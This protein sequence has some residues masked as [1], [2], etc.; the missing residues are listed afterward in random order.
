MLVFISIEQK[1]SHD[2][3][4]K[5]ITKMANSLEHRGPDDLGIWLDSNKPIAFGHRRLSIVDISASGHQPKVA[6]KTN[7]LF[8]TQGLIKLRLLSGSNHH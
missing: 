3:M 6:V 4:E 1:T 2:E 5:T 8:A 7:L